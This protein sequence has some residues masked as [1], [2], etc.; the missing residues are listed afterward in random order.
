MEILSQPPHTR[1]TSSI[2]RQKEEAAEFVA[3][4]ISELTKN[5]GVTPFEAA[6]KLYEEVKGREYRKEEVVAKL[7]EVLALK[8]DIALR[9]GELKRISPD[10]VGIFG[11]AANDSLFN[12]PAIGSEILDEKYKTAS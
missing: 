11:G 3:T 1:V 9:I 5:E 8:D 12:D 7:L 6:R 10:L 2:E 4:R